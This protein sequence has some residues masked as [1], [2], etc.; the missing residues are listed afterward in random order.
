ME[1]DGGVRLLLRRIR[2]IVQLDGGGC[3]VDGPNA[4]LGELQGSHCPPLC[5]CLVCE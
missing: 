4:G 1:L 5:L 3:L 2:W